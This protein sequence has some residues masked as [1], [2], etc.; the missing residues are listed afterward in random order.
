VAKIL[1]AD[2]LTMSTDIFSYV[3]SEEDRWH[4]GTLKKFLQGEENFSG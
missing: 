1:R 3:S 2:R 4:A